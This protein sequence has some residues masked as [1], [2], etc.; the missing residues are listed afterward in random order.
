MARKDYYAEIVVPAMWPTSE[1][2]VESC[3]YRD[4]SAVGTAVEL[5]S[6]LSRSLSISLKH[7]VDCYVA[8][9][10]ELTYE[11]SI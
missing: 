3:L 2:A 10:S 1:S 8:F 9:R 5:V 11:F 4:R 7:S 6:G